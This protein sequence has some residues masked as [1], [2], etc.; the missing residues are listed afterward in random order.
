MER[1]LGIIGVTMA[2]VFVAAVVMTSYQSGK[3]DAKKNVAMFEIAPERID[4][5]R[6]EGPDGAETLILRAGEGWILPDLGDFPADATRVKETLDR[7]LLTRRILP[8]G[9]GA[10]AQQEYKVADDDFERRLTLSEGD[11]PLTTVYLG[12]PQGPRQSHA[13]IAGDADVYAVAFGLYDAEADDSAWIDRGLLQVP[14]AEIAAIE[15]N[16]LRIVHDPAKHGAAAWRLDGT[17]SD[18]KLDSDAASRLADLVAEL[19]VEGIRDTETQP[20]YGLDDPQLSFTVTHSD[21][22]RVDYHLG[23]SALEQDWSLEA[24]IRPEHFLL[25]G[26]L[27][28]R[29]ID[30]T[31]RDVL[32]APAKQNQ[33]AAA[34]Q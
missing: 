22:K 17:G 30:A 27:A 28:H 26:Y 10:D 21:G 4:R 6:I 3:R 25:S 13:R 32:L 31:R 1:I 33:H 2:L 16:G 34:A 9:S 20:D 18:E 7:L 8:V 5:I 24:S 15:V 29:L 11:T 14:A 23:K 12:S 19:H